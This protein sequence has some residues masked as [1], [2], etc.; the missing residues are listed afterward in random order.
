MRVGRRRAKLGLMALTVA[1]LGVKGGVGKTTTAVNLAGLAAMGGLR[2]LVWDLDPQGAASFALGIDKKGRSATRHVTRKRP[3][4]SDAVFRTTTPGLDLIPADVSLRTLDLA[5]AE[6]R[7][8]KSKIGDALASIDEHYDA[9]FIDCPPGVTLANESAMR[10]AQVYL[11]PIVPSPLATRAFEQ[12]TVYVEETP[13]AVGQLFGFL[14]MVDRRK[15]AHR[16]LLELLQSRNSRILRASIPTS[17]AIENS[18]QNREPFVAGRRASSAAI[19]YRNLWTEVQ[20]R[21]LGQYNWR[22]QS[23]T[24]DSHAAES[25]P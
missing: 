25:D 6:R 24:P 10:A 11:S 7:R 3:D 15:R 22:S 1:L 9:V 8:P 13:K 12:L 19:A 2:T 16:D 21:A 4:L 20:T 17:A 23:S 18:P 14:S 5:L